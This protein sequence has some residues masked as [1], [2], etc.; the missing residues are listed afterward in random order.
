MNTH[1]ILL[2]ASQCC[3]S[4]LPI[5]IFCHNFSGQLQR[6]YVSPLLVSPI[7]S[8]YYPY[9]FQPYSPS[10]SIS[11]NLIPSSSYRLLERAPITWS[12]HLALL[13]LHV[14]ICDTSGPLAPQLHP[15]GNLRSP[16]PSWPL[17]LFPPPCPSPLPSRSLSSSTPR[18][19]PSHLRTIP[20]TDN[21]IHTYIQTPHCQ[22]FWKGRRYHPHPS[23]LLQAV[24]LPST[25]FGSVTLGR[26]VNCS[27]VKTLA[28]Y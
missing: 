3:C 2:P 22:V 10:F 12:S 26:L 28:S 20:S 14:L 4:G 9:C 11:A 24:K 13:R 19:S 6:I 18:L 27:G 25:F 5:P 1:P 15:L 23:N 7:A 16:F 8:L 17:V 21:R